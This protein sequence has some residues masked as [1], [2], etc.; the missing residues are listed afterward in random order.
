MGAPKIHWEGPCPTPGKASFDTKHAARQKAR[1]I[2]TRYGYKV[3][4][5]KCSCGAFHVTKMPR[6]QYRKMKENR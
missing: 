4:P 1:Q 2:R 6:D 5:Y 3:Y